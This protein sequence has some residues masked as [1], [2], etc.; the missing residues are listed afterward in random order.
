MAADPPAGA[1][2]PASSE[3]RRKALTFGGMSLAVVLALA[4]V[5]YAVHVAQQQ[6]A[7]SP[8]ASSNLIVYSPPMPLPSFSLK[9]LGGGS[10]V[11]EGQVAG[12]PAAVNFFASWCTACQAELGTFAAASSLERSK[13]SVLG[14]DM[15]DLAPQ[16]ALSMLQAVHAAYPVGVAHGVDLATAFGVGDLPAT[17]FI[18]AEHKIVGEVLGKLPRSELVRLMNDVAAGRSLRS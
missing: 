16:K 13:L 9:R 1:S 7:R 6:G 4:F 15:N 11:T 5:V 14:I 3:T 17:V 8:A 2:P 12:R 18:N 10:A